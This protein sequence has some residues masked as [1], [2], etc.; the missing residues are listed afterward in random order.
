MD[1]I[2]ERRDSRSRRYHTMRP[3]PSDG[4]QFGSHHDYRSAG[5]YH[6]YRQDHRGTPP[7]AR[8][9]DHHDYYSS[10][11][12][13]LQEYSLTHHGDNPAPINLSQIT[14]GTSVEVASFDGHPLYGTV[15]WLGALSGF[16][17]M[18]AGVELVSC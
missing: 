8:R 16:E 6:D 4:H 5:Q 1:K 15:K 17:G 9:H 2:I 13:Q 14:I 18:Y 3:R 10:V 7:T 11:G 12:E